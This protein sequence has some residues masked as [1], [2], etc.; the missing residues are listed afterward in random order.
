[1]RVTLWNDPH[2]CGLRIDSGWVRCP[3]D[4]HEANR[5]SLRRVSREAEEALRAHLGDL[6]PQ[7][8]GEFCHAEVPAELFPK[9]SAQPVD[10]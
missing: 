6:A 3:R 5:G 2:D 9:G 10:K 8:P 7:H 4:F 1:M